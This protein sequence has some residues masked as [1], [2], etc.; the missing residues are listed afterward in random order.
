MPKSLTRVAGCQNRLLTTD[1]WQLGQLLFNSYIACLKGQVFASNWQRTTDNYQLTTGNC[2]DLHGLLNVDKPGGMTSREVVNRIQGRL[3]RHTR[4]GH[5]GTLDPLAT[6]V[7]VIC[8][9]AATRLIEYVQRMTKTYQAR[10]RLG[11]RSDTNDADGKIEP[12][13]VSEPPESRVVAKVLAAFVGDIQQTP[14]AYSAARISGRRAYHL[15]RSGQEVSLPERPVKIYGLDLQGYNYPWLDLEVRC[16]KGTYI[17]SLARDLGERLGCGGIVE[18]LR[19]TRVGPFEAASAIAL[20]LHPSEI[21]ER[22]LPL[23]LAV[24]DL[25]RIVL[26]ES[27]I[28]RLRQGQSLP[29]AGS[30][31]TDVSVG[32]GGAPVTPAPAQVMEMAAFDSGDN[33]TAIVGAD[34]GRKVLFPIKVL[35]NLHLTS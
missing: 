20:D 5:A 13:A 26:Q 9:G 21:P 29:W 8:I 12:L 34:A 30:G 2:M 19:R 18:T 10:I 22:L 11:A 15:A 27:E 1:N 31:G 17:R 14:P 4:I 35:P 33:L 6:G 3:P 16:G 28:A 7:L 24:M 23:S 32:T 25:P